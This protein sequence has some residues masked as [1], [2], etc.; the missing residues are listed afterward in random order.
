MA[1]LKK[2]AK[3][4]GTGNPNTVLVVF[5]VLFIL[6]SIGLGVWGYYGYAEQDG[7]K[8]FHRRPSDAASPAGCD[9]G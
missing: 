2:P 7:L 8:K 6:T 9:R 5:L 3:K 1:G 4:P